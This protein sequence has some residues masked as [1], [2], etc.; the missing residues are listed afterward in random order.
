MREEAIFVKA[1]NL[2][3]AHKIGFMICSHTRPDEAGF[4]KF[5]GDGSYWYM[6]A[7]DSISNPICLLRF[8]W[9]DMI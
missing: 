7:L 8:W 6:P 3:S 1:K 9:D 5:Q 2:E 4:V